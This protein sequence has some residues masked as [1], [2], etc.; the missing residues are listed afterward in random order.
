MSDAERYEAACHAMQTGVKME[1]EL[2]MNNAH[3][4]KHLRV[5]VNSALVDNSSL[6]QLL[7][8]KG[9][10]TSD[11]FV[12]ALADG[13]EAEVQRYEQRLSERLNGKKITLR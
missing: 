8:A 11:E 2:G 4:P 13:M 7:I 9:V 12:R 3:E 6:V 1:M 10:I 5:G